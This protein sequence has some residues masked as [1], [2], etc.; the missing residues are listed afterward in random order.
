MTGSPAPVGRPP[1]AT[2]RD[3]RQGEGSWLARQPG[4]GLVGGLVFVV[5]FAVPLAFGVGGAEGSLRVL[6]PLA[7]FA[8][9]VVAV[10][11]FW[12]E[13]WPGT[14]LRAGWAG[15]AD[16]VLVIVGAV[17]LTIAGQA[18]TARPDLTGI[19]DPGAGPEHAATFPTTMPLAGAAFVVMLQLTLACERWPLVRFNRT[20]SGVLALI[21]AWAVALLLT[22]TLVAPGVVGGADFGALMVT[23]GVWQTVL[24]VVL[25]GWPLDRIESRAPRLLANN[26]AVLIGALL[27]YSALSTSVGLAAD[28]ISAVCGCV[29]AGGLLVGI[30]FEGRPRRVRRWRALT[31]VAVVSAAL[32]IV[33][34]RF[35]GTVPWQR[36]TASDWVA[37]AALNAI[38]LPVILH[39]GIGRR[40]PFPR[41]WKEREETP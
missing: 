13:D 33:L 7:T 32:F 37:H 2:P 19:F 1:S 39:V 34:T 3:V 14:R 36:A 15:W 4:L 5:P 6:G 25:Q 22:R 18:V 10:I 26:A 40:W 23:T 11:A 8:L 38:G 35:A 31:L 28:T 17:L 20:W 16:T 9:P 41:I 24:F 27:T 12:W 30:L 21:T 29:I